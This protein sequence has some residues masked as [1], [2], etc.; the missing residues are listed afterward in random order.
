MALDTGFIP[1]ITQ[2]LFVRCV[3][4]LVVTNDR[5]VT[6]TYYQVVDEGPAI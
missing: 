2:V 6:A 5:L 3:S 4:A 1:A